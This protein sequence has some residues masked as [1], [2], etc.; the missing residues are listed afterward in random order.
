MLGNWKIYF[1]LYLQSIL[2]TI[3]TYVNAFMRYRKNIILVAHMGQ[4]AEFNLR[5]C[6]PSLPKHH[7]KVLGVLYLYCFPQ[8]KIMPWNSVPIII[9]HNFFQQRVFPIS[10]KILQ[11]ASS[12]LLPTTLYGFM[13]LLKKIFNAG[14]TERVIFLGQICGPESLDNIEQIK[15]KLF[16]KPRWLH[17]MLWWTGYPQSQRGK[18]FTI[19]ILPPISV[20]TE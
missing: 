2:K 6:M 11:G 1:A 14:Y 7:W 19:R 9:Y 12:C 10:T 13:F 8:T 4:K 16:E 3:A 17:F 20:V 15:L 18:A 5:W